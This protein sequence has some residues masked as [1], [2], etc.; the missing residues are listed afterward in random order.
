MASIRLA[1]RTTLSSS[2]TSSRDGREVILLRLD[3]LRRSV[4]TVLLVA[5]SRPPRRLRG[6][7]LGA[8]GRGRDVLYGHAIRAEQQKKAVA[9]E[10]DSGDISA[11]FVSGDSTHC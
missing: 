2:S 3:R 11:S 4:Q 10:L 8:Q 6:H 1:E 7:L 9:D 5:G